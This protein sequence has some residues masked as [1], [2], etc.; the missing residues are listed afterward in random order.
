MNQNEYLKINQSRKTKIE[1]DN[2]QDSEAFHLNFNELRCINMN[3]YEQMLKIIQDKKRKI[4][5]KQKAKKT[6]R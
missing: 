5:K 1:K 3:K 6:K 4:Q 2:T